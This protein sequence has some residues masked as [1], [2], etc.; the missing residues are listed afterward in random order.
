[1]GLGF[2]SALLHVS[3]LAS[4]RRLIIAARNAQSAKF[5]AGSVAGANMDVYA[6]RN[7]SRCS[8]RL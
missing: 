8:S 1:M 2:G 5:D 4:W 6:L 3:Q 7:F